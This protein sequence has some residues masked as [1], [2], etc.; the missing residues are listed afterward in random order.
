MSRAGTVGRVVAGSGVA[1]AAAAG[2][3]LL[4]RRRRRAVDED[5]E[6]FGTLHGEVH[7]VKADDGLVLH[8]EVD[9]I[10]PYGTSANHDGRATVGSK[11]CT[12]QPVRLTLGVSTPFTPRLR[13]R[14]AGFGVQ[15]V[16]LQRSAT[17]RFT[18]SSTVRPS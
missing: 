14:S 2:G 10:A 1:V 12:K 13:R 11:L 18:V 5:R 4:D 16:M 8:A 6:P 9:E 7:E 3:F 17:L 15:D